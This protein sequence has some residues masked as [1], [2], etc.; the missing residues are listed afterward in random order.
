VQD[1]RLI[2]LQDELE[3]IAGVKSARVIGEEAPT[4]IHIVADAGRS[5]KQVVR[6]VQSLSAAGFGMPIDHRIVSVVQL[7]DQP[8]P[9]T[10]PAPPA[11]A[12]PLR[13]VLERVVQANKGDEGW[14]KVALK[15]PDGRLTEG[16][17]ASGI[18]REARA[19]AAASA[20]LEALR[21]ALESIGA[22]VDVEHLVLQH[23]GSI[24]TVAVRLA[25]YQRGATSTLVGA[26]AVQDD[27]ASAAVRAL[28]HALNRKLQPN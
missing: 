19:K 2:R 9:S 15:W 14:V 5:P 8:P 22:R 27:A 26:V 25:F 4:E 3:R 7:E 1:P 28:L 16:A 24:D 13:P 23:L 6:D 18:T 20:L 21:P 10:P 11:E 12:G 17:G